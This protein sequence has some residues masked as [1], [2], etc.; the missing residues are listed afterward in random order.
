M[1]FFKQMANR[2]KIRLH[3]LRLGTLCL[4]LLCFSWGIQA[5]SP[6]PT[7]TQN[8]DDNQDTD[9]NRPAELTGKTPV[10]ENTSDWGAEQLRLLKVLKEEIE[11]SLIQKD[12]LRLKHNVTRLGSFHSDWSQ[13]AEDFLVANAPLAELYLYDY[14]RVKS[15]RLNTKIIETLLRFDSYKYPVASLAFADSLSV[16]EYGQTYLLKLFE[17]VVSK[18]P[19]SF[20]HYF[21][22]VFGSWGSALSALDR[23]D[24]VLK[25]CEAGA[26]MDSSQKAKISLWADRPDGFW[27]QILSD[28]LKACIE[29]T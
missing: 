6:K 12:V 10:P 4:G 20:P 27:E 23:I 5:Q 8:S 15:K 29:G 24:F 26:S 7:D 3:F 9:W 13:E 28:E 22:F 25:A 17:R 11:P 1:I 19:A 14:S 18:Q 21:D 2:T 16:N